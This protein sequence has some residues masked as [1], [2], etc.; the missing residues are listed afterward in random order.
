MVT[1]VILALIV[2]AL[3]PGSHAELPALQ[4]VAPSFDLGEATIADLQR[5][6]TAGQDT[7]RSLVEKYLARI[8]ALDRQ[9]PA[10]HSIIEANP[11]ALAVADAL[12]T[13]RRTRGVRGP[14]HG[15]PIVIKDRS[16]ERRVGKECRL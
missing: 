9:G 12:D 1:A 16:E 4:Q 11:D 5:R 2:G 15:V 3:T 14:L 13:E 8:E 7:A 10:L 6:M